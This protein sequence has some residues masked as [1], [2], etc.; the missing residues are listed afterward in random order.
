MTPLVLV[1][2]GSNECRAS[3]CMYN[4]LANSLVTGYS[5]VMTIF[6][7]E[8]SCFNPTFK[9]KSWILRNKN[10]DRALTIHLKCTHM[11]Q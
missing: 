3:S 1:N 6:I 10:L 7:A 4:L 8:V 2:L 9:V 5:P 11:I